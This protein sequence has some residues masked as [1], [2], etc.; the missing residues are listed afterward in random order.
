[1]KNLRGKIEPSP[2]EPTYVKTVYGVGYKF[3]GD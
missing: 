2:E 1:V 3:A